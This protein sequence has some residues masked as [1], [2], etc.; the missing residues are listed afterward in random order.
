MLIISFISLHTC[1]RDLAMLQA[2]FL[3]RALSLH[4]Q[5]IQPSLQGLHDK[6]EGC[7]LEFQLM[8]FPDRRKVS[9]MH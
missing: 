1:T 4:G 7:F 6:L 8:V 2:N 5:L 9:D 3:E